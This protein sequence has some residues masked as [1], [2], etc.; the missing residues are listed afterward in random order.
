MFTIS[1]AIAALDDIADPSPALV[2]LSATLKAVTHDVVPLRFVGELTEQSLDLGLWIMDNVP[3]EPNDTTE[4]IGDTSRRL[5]ERGQ[6]FKAL[7]D[8]AASIFAAIGDFLVTEAPD[9]PQAPKLVA[10][11]T[12]WA[13][14]AM[15]VDQ[16]DLADLAESIIDFAETNIANLD[17]QRAPVEVSTVEATASTVVLDFIPRSVSNDYPWDRNAAD[18]L[19]LLTPDE[20]ERVPDGTRLTTINDTVAVVGT[21]DIDGDTRGGYLAYGLLTSQLAVRPVGEANT[22]DDTADD[23]ADES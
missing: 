21:D 3:G 23:T 22:A 5:I 11:M 8:E 4:T 14:T 16:P 13:A 7:A 19:W 6:G 12:V 17:T 2:E 15:A 10:Q 18:V 9:N 1:N 20:L